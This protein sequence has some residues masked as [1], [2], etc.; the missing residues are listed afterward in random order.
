MIRHRSLRT[1]A[2]LFAAAAG[3]YAANCALGASV[4]VRLIDTSGF[5]WLHHALYIVTCTTS[6]VAVGAGLASRSSAARNAALLL[7]PAAVPLTAIARVGARTRRHP[8][9]A[10]GAA[11]FFLAAVIRSCRP[12]RK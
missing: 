5:R 10:L 11:P 4:A 3:A 12:D 2:P 6:A 8:L 7:M 9:I 1:A